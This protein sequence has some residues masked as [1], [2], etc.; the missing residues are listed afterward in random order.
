MKQRNTCA[1]GGGDRMMEGGREGRK[2]RRREMDKVRG[3]S[4]EDDVCKMT[5]ND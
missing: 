5:E 4:R 3:R 2:M 1:D